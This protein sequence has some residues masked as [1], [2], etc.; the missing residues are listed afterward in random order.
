MT[1]K[2]KEIKILLKIIK[3]NYIWHKKHNKYYL[4]EACQLQYV[5]LGGKRK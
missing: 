1:S 3:E 4:C 5:L 2:L